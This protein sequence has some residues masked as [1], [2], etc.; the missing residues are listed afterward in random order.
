[1]DVAEGV[2]EVVET[3]VDEDIS[4]SSRL[5]RGGKSQ[6]TLRWEGLLCW[7]EL[8]STQSAFI[9]E[10]GRRNSPATGTS[11]EPNLDDHFPFEN[12]RRSVILMTLISVLFSIFIFIFRNSHYRI[13]NQI[14]MVQISHVER[15]N[16]PSL[17]SSCL[18]AQG[19][20]MTQSLSA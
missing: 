8:R 2:V 5:V 1:M 15:S 14:A 17:I 10:R 9:S 16:L 12:F 20:A 6:V 4:G 18:R 3:K 13:N 7:R 11:V 19:R